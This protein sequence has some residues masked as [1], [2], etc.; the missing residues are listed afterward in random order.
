MCPSKTGR[1]PS[2]TILFYITTK[3]IIDM[4]YFHSTEPHARLSMGFFLDQASKF[5]NLEITHIAQM[6]MLPEHQPIG[7][8]PYLQVW[9]TETGR[10]IVDMIPL[11]LGFNTI[12]YVDDITLV[13]F[14][15][16][17]PG[18]PPSVK[19]DSATFIVNKI[20][21]Q[22]INLE[23]EGVFKYSSF[24]YHLLLY[25][26]P[27]SFP[28]HI[29]KLDSRGNRRFVIFWSS[30]FHNSY[31]SPYT[32]NEFI[33]LFVHPTSTL[34]IGHPPPRLSGDIK[35]ILQLSRQYK[36]GDWY[37][38]QN[39][40]EIR[41][42]VCELCPFKLPKYVPMRLFALE[43]FRQLINVDLTHFCNAKKK[44]QLRIKNQ[45]GPF[46]IHKREA[47]QDAEEILGEHLKLKKSFWWVPY[48]PNSFISDRKVRN[49]LS[50]YV[51]HNIPEIEQFANQDEWVEGTLI[52][53]ITEQ[54]KMEKAMK[55][56]E[57]TLDLDS[58]GQVSFKLPQ[59]IGAGTS[60]V[61]TCQ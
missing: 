37:L 20:H 60:F 11:V 3:S 55:H 15:M 29:R 49:R 7:P 34:L 21:D 48:D 33:D 47:W 12:E 30:V 44:A 4:I 5:P 50:V 18:Q 10:L 56:L 59:K 31:D 54:E 27:D 24:I 36:I 45:L 1:S 6:F 28:F 42:Y 43:Y 17:T 26:H 16:F 23:R 32:Y 35:K 39:H 58:F 22:F 51:Y 13:L 52:E 25:Y 61:G 40:T 19:Y 2:K 38:Y 9:F 41:I 46:I 53:E 8:P 57:K 14:A